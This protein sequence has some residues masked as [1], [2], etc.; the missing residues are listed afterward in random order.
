MGRHPEDTGDL[1]NLELPCLQ[2]LRLFRGDANGRVFH[3]LLQHGDLIAVAAAAEG[4]LPTLPDTLRVFDRPRM[5]QH[6]ARSRAVGKELRPI[7]LTG[8]RHADGVLRHSDGGIAHQPVKAKP[9]DVQHIGRMQPDKTAF[10]RRCVIHADG[11]FV[12]KLS[13]AVAIHCHPVRH[14][15]IEGNNLALAVPDNLGIGVAPQEQMRH[16]RFPE[17][18]GTHLRVWL[19]MQEQIQRMV[20]GFLLAAVLLVTV[21]VQR[22]TCHRFRQD[23]DTGIHR[24]HLHGRPLINPLARSASSKEKAVGAAHG[25]VL[26]LIP[27]TEKP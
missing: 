4:G 27:G 13:L 24:R 20:N 5:L 14:Q 18:E 11:V 8:N 22:Q 3:A 12:I 10:D 19:V 21:E 2:K 16:E 17:H 25:A 23:A 6:A 26:G 9:W 1:I 7:F 15:R